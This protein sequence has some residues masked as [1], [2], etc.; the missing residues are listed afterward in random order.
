MAYTV[1]QLYDDGDKWIGRVTRQCYGRC[2]LG[3]RLEYN[4]QLRSASSERGALLDSHGHRELS[5]YCEAVHSV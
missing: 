5:S 2:R 3:K 4:I 1:T